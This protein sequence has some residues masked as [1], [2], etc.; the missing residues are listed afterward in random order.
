MKYLI[1]TLLFCS[2]ISCEESFNDSPSD[3]KEVKGISNP[4]NAK[5]TF[6]ATNPGEIND[7]SGF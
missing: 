6:G 1:F 7:G 3:T 2:L 4:Y 5:D